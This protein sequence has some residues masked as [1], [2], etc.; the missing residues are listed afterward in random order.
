MLCLRQDDIATYNLAKN[1]PGSRCCQQ[2]RHMPIRFKVYHPKNR[3]HALTNL[4][5]FHPCNQ[6]TRTLTTTVIDPVVAVGCHSQLTKPSKDDRCW[7]LH[8][9]RTE[10]GTVKGAKI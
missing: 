4:Q 6:L 1:G 10:I 8:L 7:C 2:Q 5:M 9:H 3:H